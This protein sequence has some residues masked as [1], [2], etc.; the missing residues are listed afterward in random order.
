MNSTTAMPY[1][2][3]N[4]QHINQKKKNKTRMREREH[5]YYFIFDLFLLAR[6]SK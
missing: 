4:K 6:K 1:T 5:E 2:Y 3:I